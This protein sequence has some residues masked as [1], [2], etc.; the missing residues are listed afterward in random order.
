MI[1]LATIKA[2]NATISTRLPSPVCVFLGGTTGIGFY[3]LKK[4]VASTVSP[5]IYYIGRTPSN[6]EI[7][8]KALQEINPKGTYIFIQCDIMVIKNIDRA[9]EEILQKEKEINLLWLSA[10][11]FRFGA[12]DTADGLDFMAAISYYCPTKFI[13]NLLPLLKASASN[14]HFT[15]VIRILGGGMEKP[16]DPDDLGIR[17]AS[18]FTFRQRHI[19]STT[20]G[21]DYLAKE[22]P[23]ISF[24]H[25][26]PGLVKTEGQDFP[27]MFSVLVRTVM[28]IAG[29]LL[30][31]SEEE[32]AERNLFCATS[33]IYPASKNADEVKRLLGGKGKGEGEDVAVGLDGIKGSGCY[34]I[35]SDGTAKCGNKFLV[36]YRENGFRE[37][38]WEH[39]LDVYKSIEEK[40]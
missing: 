10:G 39:T 12:P 36:E 37:K 22:N 16:L 14:N 13:V 40:Y 17:K 26:S 15:R 23:D 9:C 20:V 27:G 30:V 18:F 35:H 8:Q 1:P 21:L 5:K 19:A 31:I 34:T 4:L 25:V 33:E 2:A 11:M 32:S 3:T 38:F 24:L 6:A 29:S 28:W 7:V